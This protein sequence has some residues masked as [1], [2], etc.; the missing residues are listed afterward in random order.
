MPVCLLANTCTMEKG[1]E[2]AG[3][4]SGKFWRNK[5]VYKVKYIF[6]LDLDSIRT[7]RNFL[8]GKN[9]KK[10]KEITLSNQASILHRIR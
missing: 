10:R 1:Y 3:G 7:K 8:F 6:Y 4:D 9:L 5:C 2:F